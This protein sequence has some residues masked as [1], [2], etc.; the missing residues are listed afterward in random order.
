M[1]TPRSIKDIARTLVALAMEQRAVPRVLR[2]LK[3]VESAFALDTHLAVDLDESGVALDRR[4]RA[5]RGVLEEAVHLLVG[6]AVLALQTRG[7][8][9]EISS[10]RSAVVSE[11]ADRAGHREA[12]VRTAIPLTQTERDGITQ[13]LVKRFGGT[14]DVEEHHDPSLLGGIRIHIGDLVIDDSVAGKLERLTHTLYV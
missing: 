6:N 4:Q 10:L 9:R 5:L 11:A 12:S 2:D 3:T 14:V 7:L 13:S 8:L 1:A